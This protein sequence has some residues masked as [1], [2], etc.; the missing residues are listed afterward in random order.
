M[1]IISLLLI[2]T[3]CSCFDPAP[4]PYD[5]RIN[6]FRKKVGLVVIDTSF[7]PF[8]RKSTYSKINKIYYSKRLKLKKNIYIDTIK[9]PV[10]WCKNIHLN[11]KSGEIEYEED[12][13]RS[14]EYEPGVDFTLFESL[15]CRYNFRVIKNDK[16]QSKGWH[17]IYNVPVVWNVTSNRQKKNYYKMET[18]EL[19]KKQADSILDLWRL[20]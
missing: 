8:S 16:H 5:E 1:K 13:Y 20:K 3:F 9:S 19:N 15:I 10:Y 14:G 7:V 17:Y 18:R 4:Y 2:L 12:V 11:K 6:D